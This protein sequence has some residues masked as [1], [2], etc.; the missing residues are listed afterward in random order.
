MSAENTEYQL[1]RQTE[2]A[3]SLL[4][5]LRAEFERGHVPRGADVQ[6]SMRED[7]QPCRVCS[8]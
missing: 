5:D 7:D 1:R 4:K 8:L 6:L 2:E 3:R